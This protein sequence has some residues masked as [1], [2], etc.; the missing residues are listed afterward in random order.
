MGN[1]K[2]GKGMVNSVHLNFMYK[3]TCNHTT[4]G[5]DDLTDKTNVPDGVTRTSGD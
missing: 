2:E 3:H 1:A 5:G 4:H